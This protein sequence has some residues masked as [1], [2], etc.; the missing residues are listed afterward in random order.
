MQNGRICY[1]INFSWFGNMEEKILGA[2]LLGNSLGHDQ[3]KAIFRQVAQGLFYAHDE[4]V[5]HRNVQPKN[6]LMST[7]GNVELIDFG[8]AKLMVEQ[9]VE[10]SMGKSQL[11][12]APPPREFDSPRHYESPL[13][14]EFDGYMSG[15]E[16][17]VYSGGMSDDDYDDYDDHDDY[18]DVYQ[19]V[20]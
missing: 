11:R 10:M 16:G 5:A 6:I 14:D 12:S 4:G 13:H 20:Q 3:L 7:N 2:K 8:F 19:N 1:A 18:E 17:S 15:H 9:P